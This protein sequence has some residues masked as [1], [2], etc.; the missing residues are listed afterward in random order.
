MENKKHFVC[1]GGC[2]GVSDKPMKCQAKECAKYG[3][4]LIECDC[5]DDGHFGNN[6]E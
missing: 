2:K 3:K 1:N 4:A 5:T 6:E